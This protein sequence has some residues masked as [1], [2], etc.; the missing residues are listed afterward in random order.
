MSFKR[1]EKLSD[2]QA[3]QLHQLYQKEWWTEGRTLPDVKI[4]LRNTDIIVALGEEG[5]NRL[6]AFARVL[7]DRVYKALILDVIVD[8]NYRTRGLGKEIMQMILDHPELGAVKHFELYCLP[9]LIP[10]YKKW[11]FTDDLGELTTMRLYNNNK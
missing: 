2:Q 5:S 1:I 11:G 10:F 7:T 6:I 8:A 3:R 4:M 9:D